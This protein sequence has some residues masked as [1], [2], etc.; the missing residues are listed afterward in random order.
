M[1]LERPPHRVKIC[2]IERNDPN[3]TVKVLEL[4][5]KAVLG[6]VGHSYGSGLGILDY[7][8]KLNQYR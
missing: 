8:K 1:E 5:S 3:F 7:P 4:L 6:G 2:P